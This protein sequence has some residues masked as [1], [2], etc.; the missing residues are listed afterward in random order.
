[1]RKLIF[2]HS[3]KSYLPEIRNWV[4]STNL[5]QLKFISNQLVQ[6]RHR[7]ILVP[8]KTVQMQERIAKSPYQRCAIDKLSGHHTQNSRKSDEYLALVVCARPFAETTF[9]TTTLIVSKFEFYNSSN[10]IYRIYILM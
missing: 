1:M 8:K 10:S 7:H 4:F 3:H 6:L 5:N 2:H 9:T